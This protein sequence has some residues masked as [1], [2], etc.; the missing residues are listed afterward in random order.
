MYTQNEET[1]PAWFFQRRR[2]TRQKSDAG[3]VSAGLPSKVHVP[4]P[5]ENITHEQSTQ[6]HGKRLFKC[7]VQQTDSH[8]FFRLTVS[9]GLGCFGFFCIWSRCCSVFGCL[10]FFFQGFGGFF[11]LFIIL[12][13]PSCFTKW[14][15]W[16]RE[17]YFRSGHPQGVRGSKSQEKKPSPQRKT[18]NKLAF[19][20]R[21]TVVKK[22]P[23]TFP[24]CS[25]LPLARA[26][27]EVAVQEH[28]LDS[29]QGMT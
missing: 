4:S 12:F 22:I 13:Q 9:S 20:R 3:A 18:Q 16:V 27:V 14:D 15:S 7:S 11:R 21:S 10:G 6:L 5:L 28:D 19:S 8:L 17:T 26:G 2:G 24:L 29:T 23:P 1:Q 25:A